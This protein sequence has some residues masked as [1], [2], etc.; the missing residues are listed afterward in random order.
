MRVFCP[1]CGEK[2]S[3]DLEVVA[4]GD[5]MECAKCGVDLILVMKGGKFSLE[6]AFGPSFD[7]LEEEDLDELDYDED[8]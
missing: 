8:Y 1:D 2:I 6:T 5:T 4:E 7:D 3:L